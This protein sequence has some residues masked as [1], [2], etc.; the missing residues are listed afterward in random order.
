MRQLLVAV[1]PSLLLLGGLTATVIARTRPDC[2]FMGAGDGDLTV[3]YP[4]IEQPGV[5]IELSGLTVGGLMAGWLGGTIDEVPE[6][7]EAASPAHN[8]DADTPPFLVIHGSDDEYTPVEMSRNFVAAMREAGRD[9]EY[10]ELPGGHMEVPNDPE[11]GP[12]IQRFLVDRMQPE[13]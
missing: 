13:Q 12:A 8:I 1:T 2:V 4:E 6:V 9:V 5:P 10:L 7:W 3:P 11:F